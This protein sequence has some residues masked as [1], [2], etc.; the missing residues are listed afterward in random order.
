MRHTRIVADIG[1]GVAILLFGACSNFLLDPEI[2]PDRAPVSQA[3]EEDEPVGDPVPVDD[4]APDTL[5]LVIESGAAP[6]GNSTPASV[7]FVFSA[8]VH[9][10]DASD[11]SI[12]S[13]PPGASIGDFTGSGSSYSAD[14]HFAGD[15]EAT[16]LVPSGGATDAAT[17]LL[18]SPPGS[19]TLAHDSRATARVIEAP[20][21]AGAEAGYETVTY[22][23]DFGEEVTGFA[24]DDIQV[25]NGTASILS[26]DGRSY[27]FA[28]TPAT[29][30]AVS[31]SVP[32]GAVRDGAGNDSQACSFDYT[33]NSSLVAVNVV[34]IAAAATDV[35]PVSLTI[36]FDL[37]MDGSDPF[38]LSDITVGNAGLN[39]LTDI[40]AGAQTDYE[41]VLAPTSEGVVDIT[42][43][44][45]ATETAAGREN[46][47]SVLRFYYDPQPPA[48][49]SFTLTKNTSGD[50]VG[51]DDFAND[52]LVVG[53][54]AAAYRNADTGHTSGESL[55]AI[56]YTTDGGTSW[57]PFDSGT[58]FLSAESTYPG[59][60]VRATDEAGNVTEG[61]AI[62]NVTIDRK[63]V[64]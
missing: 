63:S 18:V 12:V 13:D 24:L 54:D 5:S 28:V 45:G 38:E 1:L 40:S 60:N 2:D 25:T 16:V 52:I 56:E 51:N 35:S 44:Q 6:V 57:Q 10:F 8:A 43:P 46:M 47:E 41:L 22:T 49:P 50:A 31:I 26:D 58:A 64:V 30:G 27:S 36:G 59:I 39:S 32:A 19:L 14:L 29:D 21:S 62:V 3:T 17:G 42:I 4:P 15:G 33:Y 23:V 48:V 9:D 34:G 61:T 53:I 55:L 20:F 11:V 7:S 37:A